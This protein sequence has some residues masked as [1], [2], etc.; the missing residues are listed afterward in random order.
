MWE[1]MCLWD[2]EGVCVSGR[3]VFSLGVCL[4]LWVS[5]TVHLCTW[6]CHWV[7]IHACILLRNSELTSTCCFLS[8]IFP[9]PDL[10][11]RINNN[12]VSLFS[13][14]KIITYRHVSFSNLFFLLS[15]V[16]RLSRHP[17]STAR[18]P[19]TAKTCASSPSNLFV[20]PMAVCTTASAR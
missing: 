17:T 6:V 2:E 16:K 3:G 20:P 4:R 19:S 13:V 7:C 9:P 8:N 10:K 14:I 12:H 1:G 18:R 11:S 15:T 5:M